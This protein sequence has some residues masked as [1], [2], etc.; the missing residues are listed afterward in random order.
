MAGRTDGDARASWVPLALEKCETYLWLSP[1]FGRADVCLEPED[2]WDRHPVLVEFDG[3]ERGVA[4]TPDR[5]GTKAARGSRYPAHD[6][7]TP[8]EA[9]TMLERDGVDQA[10][11]DRLL[12]GYASELFRLQVPTPA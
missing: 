12:G 6:T 9:R 4:R 1:Q 7:S 5:I 3:W 10:T 2:V 11:I 8:A